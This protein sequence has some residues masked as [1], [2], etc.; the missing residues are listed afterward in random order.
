MVVDLDF[1]KSDNVID[2]SLV[3]QVVGPL[4]VEF[5]GS[6]PPHDVLKAYLL[7]STPRCV[8]HMTASASVNSICTKAFLE[9]KAICRWTSVYLRA[10]LGMTYNRIRLSTLWT[11]LAFRS[12]G[13]ICKQWKRIPNPLISGQEDLNSFLG[14][15]VAGTDSATLGTHAHWRPHRGPL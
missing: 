14:P 5:D 13:W 4:S 1:L 15:R 10:M 9:L 3:V 2:E 12:A 11:C 7:Q 8:Y 6:E